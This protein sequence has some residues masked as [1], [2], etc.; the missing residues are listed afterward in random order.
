MVRG[1][2][3]KEGAR[4]LVLLPPGDAARQQPVLVGKVPAE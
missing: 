1:E 3:V 2:G 4:F